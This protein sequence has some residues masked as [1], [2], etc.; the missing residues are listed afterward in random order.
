M[1]PLNCHKSI[2]TVLSVAL[3]AGKLYAAASP[4][5]QARIGLKIRIG[6]RF[7]NV[8]MCV[9]SPAGAKGGVAADISVF[10]E[11]PVNN[12][13]AL[14]HFDL[15]LMRPILFAF[16]FRMLQFEPIVTLKY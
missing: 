13:E 12:N 11:F 8:R 4:D 15:P 9:A 10:A 1:I 5:S 2:A 7:D 14:L 6:G 3:L 16:A